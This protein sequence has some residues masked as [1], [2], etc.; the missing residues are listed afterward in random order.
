MIEQ[1]GFRRALALAGVTLLVSAAAGANMASADNRDNRLPR[2]QANMTRVNALIH[3]M[4]LDEKISLL[5]GSPG[6]GT[7]DPQSVGQAGFVPGVPR[8]GIPALRFTDGP[9]GVRNSL[10]T[11]ALPAPVSLAASFSTELAN[12]YGVVLGRDSQATNQ[13][14]LFGPMVNLVRVPQAGRNFETLGEDPLL[15]SDLVAAEVRGIQGEGTIATIKHYAENNQENN[16]QNVNVVVDDQT[17]HE[18]ELPAFQAAVD[19]GTGAVMCSYPL[20]NG[21]HAC[22]NGALLTDILREQ[23]GFTGWVLTDFGAGRNVGSGDVT[24]GQ[25][26]P[27]QAS[28][29]QIQ[30]GL[31]QEFASN[32]FATIKANVTNRAIPESVVN[33]AV[34]HILTTMDRFGLLDHASPIG[35]PV[36]AKPRPTINVQADAGIARTVA[37]AGAVL[38][39]NDGAAL[40]LSSADQRSLA[41]VGPTARQL[42]VGGGGSARVIGFTDREI[43]P[44][45][46]LRAQAPGANINYSVGRDLD[47][48]AV[49]AAVLT[50]PGGTAGTGLLRT[51]AGGGATQVDPQVNFTGS[52]A[53]PAGSQNT[54]TGTLTVPVTGSYDLKIQGTGGRTALTLRAPDGSTVAA[55]NTGGLFGGSVIPTTDGL[56]NGT[57]SA[58]LTAGVAYAVTITGTAAATTPLQIR[59]AW[60]T[61]QQRQADVD[62]AVAAA[63][64][65][66]TA[67]VFAYDEGTEGVDR[68]SLSLPGNQ[69]AL[70]DAVAAAN[71][72]T[73]VVLNTG[74]PVLMPWLGH[75]KSVLEMWYPGQEGGPATADLLLG[76]ASPGG[77]LPVTFP[78]A[79][80]D[81]P[82]AGN[83]LRY[84]G[85]PLAGA[86]AGQTVQEYSEGIL[87]GYRWYDA[88]HITPLFP[89]GAGLSY[90]TFAYS[91]LK[92]RPGKGG[93]DVTFDVRN[94]G[95]RSGSEVAQVYL[96]A[97]P[98]R[99]A[100]MAES[101]LAGFSR[102]I[103]NPHQTAHVT[104]HI[105]TRQ[106]SYWSSA[107]QDWL[108]AGG[109]RALRVGGSSRDISLSTTITVN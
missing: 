34:R 94:S 84:P 90:T 37:T 20:V 83:P 101:A 91:N 97:P 45:D 46:A 13:D 109:Q 55:T 9:A 68:A 60:V 35:A 70:I 78:A 42:L 95:S 8:L 11:T 62:A 99:P 100:P 93:Y 40:P 67:I 86:P 33:T 107:Q 102:V 79:E 104:V 24:S 22:S 106:L 17:L 10:N 6:A 25:T 108:V 36:T 53:L 58:T 80:A 27:A 48:V 76:R 87:V 54:W 4:T 98:N 50:P 12:R 88:Q 28:A 103:L 81:T 77:K 39:K 56:A 85:V 89:F 65:A 71:P 21:V 30:A 69:D 3:A 63:R 73:I 96:G 23:W 44:L 105:G 75:V 66:R 61:P 32:N 41:V 2:A 16:R 43:S 64:S 19:A 5:T 74:D 49:P 82:V 14:V 31:D 26:T 15:Q 18:M 29:Y 57:A 59:F 51:P 1:T 52:S 38:L 72:N 47:G 7:P 92:V